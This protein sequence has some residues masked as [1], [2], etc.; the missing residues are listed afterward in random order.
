[1]QVKAGWRMIT[2][3]TVD[4]M[5][6]SYHIYMDDWESSVGAAVL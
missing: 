6:R 5:I 1:M 3:F 2:Y 4:S